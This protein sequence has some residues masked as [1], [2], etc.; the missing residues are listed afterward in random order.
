MGVF[1]GNFYN[2]GVDFYSGNSINASDQ[3][4][5]GYEDLIVVFDYANDAKNRT[6]PASQFNGTSLYGS[7]PTN[8]S[9]TLDVNGVNSYNAY[10]PYSSAESHY[11]FNLARYT[12]YSYPINYGNL[13]G[14]ADPVRMFVIF[15]VNPNDLKSD[16][17]CTMTLDDKVVTFETGSVSDIRLPD[18]IMWVEDDFEA[19]YAL[20][21]FKWRCDHSYYWGVY[22]TTKYFGR[23]MQPGS[24]MNL[25]STTLQR[26]L[27]RPRMPASP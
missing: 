10:D 23:H 27:R 16:G 11:A 5:E 19:A 15:Y 17:V 8:S 4:L 6:L 12:G 14:G 3:G 20:A 25:I 13:L 1:H 7:N 26:A 24:D 22:A 18:E 2:K 21:S 9:I